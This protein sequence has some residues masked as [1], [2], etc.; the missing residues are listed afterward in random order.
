MKNLTLILSLTTLLSCNSTQSNDE[1][2]TKQNDSLKKVLDSISK[3]KSVETINIQDGTG[4]EKSSGVSQKPNK[5]NTTT[6]NIYYDG[7]IELVSCNSGYRH[8]GMFVPTVSLQFK[9]I[10]QDDI[11]K[12]VGVNVVYIDNKKDEQIGSI[13]RH[14]CGWTTKLFAAGTKMTLNFDNTKGW[15][16]L[17]DQDVTAKIY[18]GDDLIKTIK[19]EN[20]EVE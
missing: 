3:L 1:S 4:S 15:N 18:F 17:N 2:L 7:K 14:L 19:V 6:Q 20:S 5:E 13:Q 11:I 9:N 12:Y 8:I 16:S 10:S